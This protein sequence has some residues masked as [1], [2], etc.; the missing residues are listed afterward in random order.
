MRWAH[1]T[2][3]KRRIHARGAH[4]W[5]RHCTDYP[6]VRCCTL[7]YV[8]DSCQVR[9]R[10]EAEEGAERGFSRAKMGASMSAQGPGPDPQGRAP[11]SGISL[12]DLAHLSVVRIGWSER[13]RRVRWCAHLVRA[14]RAHCSVHCG[15][16]TCCGVGSAAALKA[17]AVESAMRAPGVVIECASE[18]R[19]QSRQW[20]SSQCICSRVRRSVVCCC[21]ATNHH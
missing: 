3:T 10:R 19:A 9:G 8:A 11:G 16:S 5:H 17:R 7:L 21:S 13:E 4:A 14:A 15:G 2:S 12:S 1:S 20:S 6:S 18:G